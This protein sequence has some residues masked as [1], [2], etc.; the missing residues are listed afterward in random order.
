MPQLFPMNWM[1]L[2]LLF[3]ITIIITITQMYFFFF[4]FKKN[5]T[6]MKNYKNIMFKW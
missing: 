2:T 6:F 5:Y 4:K 1:I 3:S